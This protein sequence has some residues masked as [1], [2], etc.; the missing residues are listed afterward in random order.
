MTKYLLAVLLAAC[1]GAKTSAP[2]TTPPPAGPSAA[3]A[4]KPTPVPDPEI[5]VWSRSEDCF[6]HC[7]RGEGRYYLH[8]SGH[9]VSTTCEVQSNSDP[10]KRSIEDA[11]GGPIATTTCGALSPVDPAQAA[12][13]DGLLRPGYKPIGLKCSDKLELCK[14]LGVPVLSYGPSAP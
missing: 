7:V 1:G 12:T 11:S 5:V 13:L 3:P 10:A 2:A 4:A 6:G 9:W 8:Q 14:Q